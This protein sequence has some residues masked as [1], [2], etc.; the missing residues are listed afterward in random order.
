LNVFDLTPLLFRIFEADIIVDSCSNDY[1]S[2]AKTTI[3][4]DQ[5]EF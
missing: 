1:F 3:A 2:T 4:T 5:N